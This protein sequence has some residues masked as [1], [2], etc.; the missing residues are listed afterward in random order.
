MDHVGDLAKF[1]AETVAPTEVRAKA[2]LVLVDTIGAIVGGADEAE[3]RALTDRLLFSGKGPALVIGHGAKTAPQTAAFLNGTSGTALEMDEG[4]QFC[5]G[6]PGIHVIP[7]ALAAASGGSF[8]GQDLLTAI[9]SGYEAAARVGIATSLRPSMHPH[10]TWGAIGAIT[11]VQKLRGTSAAGLRDAMNMAANL[12]LTTSRR[13]MLEGGTVRN[14]FAGMSNQVGLLVS[15]MVAAGFSGDRDGVRQV[16]GQVASDCFD[17]GQLTDQLGERWEIMRN[18]FKMH[19]CCRFN[20]AALDALDILLARAPKFQIDEIKDIKV[21]TYGLAVELD[22]AAPKNV[23]AAKFSVPFAIATRLVTGS[24]AVESFA[25]VRV[26]DQTILALA[27]RVKLVENAGMSAKLPDKRPA[28]VTIL[29]QNGQEYGAATDTNRGDWAD[30]FSETEL[31]AKFLSL[32]ARRWSRDKAE[33]VWDAGLGLDDLSNF[34]GF[35]G[36]LAAPDKRT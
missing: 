2:A 36:L 22:D 28:K 18:Y 31:K 35:L 3:N 24:T 10:G 20:H 13:T 5:K 14:V 1:L 29:L 33:D 25:A 16:F 34:S 4:H 27:S 8:S 7:A 15:D 32:T 11:T 19:S 6:H 26:S 23:L 9:A 30:P 12:G 17:A 21:E